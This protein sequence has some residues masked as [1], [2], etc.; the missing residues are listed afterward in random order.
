MTFKEKAHEIIFE[1]D[2]PAGKSFDIALLF[3][4][5]VSILVVMLESVSDFSARHNDFLQLVEWAL[6]VIFTIEYLLRLWVTKKPLVY[7]TSFFGAVDLVAL[8][9]Q[10]I[11]L[12]FGTGHG[13]LVIRALRLLR[14]FRVL[15][16]TRYTKESR[17]LT[18]A[19]W[20]SRHKISVFLFTVLTLV[21][22][23]GSI[24][25]LIEGEDHGFTSIPTGIYWAIVTMTTVGYG[26]LTPQTDLGK[27]ISSFVMIIGYGIIAV[28]TGIVS[29]EISKSAKNFSNTQVCTNC[30]KDDHEDGANYCS[31]CGKNLK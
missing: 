24:M 27:F 17:V 25:Y 26:D 15:K 5:F 9:P 18:S 2:T 23:I 8:L 3:F 21:L 6:T 10:Y 22:I 28:P 11:G 12:L 7:A 29:H 16:F 13:L 19:L 20:A 1:A 31:R 30:M 14:I 4:I